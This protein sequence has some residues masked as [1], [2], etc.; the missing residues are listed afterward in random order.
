MICS[1]AR[2]AKQISSMRLR[3]IH[4]RRAISSSLSPTEYS[5][6]GLIKMSQV[7]IV[8]HLL[9]DEWRQYVDD[10]PKGSIFHTPEMY[11]V[12]R[13]ARRHTPDLWAAKKDEHILALLTPVR[14]NYKDGLL[15][16][17]STR[18]VVYGG[19]LYNP[20]RQGEEALELLLHTYKREVDR[21]TL[22]TEVRNLSSIETIRS[23]L[24]SQGFKYEE[25]LNYLIDLNRPVEAIFQGIG[26]RTRKNIRRG[27]NQGKVQ[28]EQIKDRSLISTGYALLSQTFHLAHVPLAD[29][30]LFEA[31]F[32]ILFPKNMVRFTLAKV[33]QIPAAISVE[34]LY[35]D[36]VYGWFGGMNRELS[37]YNPNEMLMWEILKWSAEN[38]YRTYDFGG[39]GRPDEEYGVRQFKAKFGGE[40]VN[41]GRIV[42]VQYPEYF[43]IIKSLYEIYRRMMV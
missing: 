17:F 33:D 21:K 4:A 23:L 16:R 38:G 9:E 43:G 6:S 30:S 22:F 39:A 34:L 18:E 31:A 26:P 36:T 42:W 27:L 7:T 24:G 35:K 1:V 3:H 41:F 20:D 25:H 14:I 8:R 10:H 13:R 5:I 12:F 28:V 15:D 37:S 2:S 40:L 19:L 32:D 11:E 29:F